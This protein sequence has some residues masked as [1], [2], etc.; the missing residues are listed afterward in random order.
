MERFRK[1]CKSLAYK[2][3][4]VDRF[5][6]GSVK[7]CH[8]VCLKID[9]AIPTGQNGVSLSRILSIFCSWVLGIFTTFFWAT[10][11]M[12]W[13]LLKSKDFFFLCLSPMSCI[14]VSGC[15]AF[16]CHWT[17]KRVSGSILYSL[18]SS[19]NIYTAGLFFKWCPPGFQVLPHKVA[20]QML[21]LQPRL[22]CSVMASHSVLSFIEFQGTSVVQFLHSGPSEWKPI[23]L[24]NQALL[25]VF[26]CW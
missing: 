9:K 8:Y 14:S 22:M 21:S 10:Y 3:P 17:I 16:F 19:G 12:V 5:F 2:I 15:Y 4:E 23:H 7:G 24:L 11:S 13:P 1:I 26:N 6:W 25:P 20:F 18:T